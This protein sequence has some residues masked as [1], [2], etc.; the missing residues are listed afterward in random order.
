M[1]VAG[2]Y[3]ALWTVFWVF[4]LITGKEGMGYG[5]FK[6]RRPRRLVWL[7]IPADDHINVVFHRFHRRYSRRADAAI[8]MC[9]FPSAPI[10]LWRAG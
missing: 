9:P 7:A 1:G 10:Y 6:Y 3:M 2:G 4:K 5:D 8:A